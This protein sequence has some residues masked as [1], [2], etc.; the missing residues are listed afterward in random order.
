MNLCPSNFEPGN[1]SKSAWKKCQM[2]EIYWI[3]AEL[4]DK[5]QDTQRAIFRHILEE[6][7]IDIYNTFN[8]ADREE[9]TVTAILKMKYFQPY[10]NE[11]YIR[12]LFFYV[13]NKKASQSMTNLKHNAIDYNFGD[14]T[15]SMIKERK[16][17]LRNQK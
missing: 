1:D 17:C 8:T 10:K 5:T 7:G 16:N 9:V 13:V 11:T 3:A 6:N 4:A 12:S 15:Y 14:I 2:I